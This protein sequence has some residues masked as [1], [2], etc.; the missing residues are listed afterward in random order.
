MTSKYVI[1][2]DGLK[3]NVFLFEQ[4]GNTSKKGKAFPVT[5]RGGP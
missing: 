2:T 1:Q 5:G 4:S 3:L